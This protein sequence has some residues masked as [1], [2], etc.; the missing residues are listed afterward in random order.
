MATC[1]VCATPLPAGSRFCFACG[2]QV[3]NPGEHEHAPETP[4]RA[5]EFLARLRDRLG[6]EY[7]IERE[8]GR[9]GM[10]IVYLAREKA[11]DR[12]VALKVLPPALAFD[13]SIG[14]RFLREARLAAR[15]DH[16]NI[17]PIHRVGQAG[18]I[19]YFAMKYVAGGSLQALLKNTPRLS[20]HETRRIL[21]ACAHALGYAHARG[22]VH[23]DVK[24]ANILLD[25]GGRVYVTDLGIAKAAAAEG[26]LTRSGAVIGTP[27]YMAPEQCRGEAAD[28]RSDQ[29]ALAIVGYQMLAGR[30]PF[31]QK[32]MEG[33]MYDRLFTDPEPL[34]RIAPD[35]PTVVRDA[36]HRALSREPADRFPT[37]EE[38]AQAVV[39][40]PVEV[41][42]TT[43][44]GQT[45]RYSATPTAGAPVAPAAP[46]RGR[47]RAR[48][49]IAVAAVA[50]A[51]GGG[52]WWIWLRPSGDEAAQPA[53]V[54][55]P[56]A[57]ESEGAGAGPSSAPTAARWR[58]AGAPPEGYRLAIDGADAAERDGELEPGPHTAS[59]S[60]PGYETWTAER[61]LAAGEIWE[62]RPEMTPTATQPAS[63]PA[64]QGDRRP[65]ETGRTEAPEF[66]LS[67]IRVFLDDGLKL[68]EA[69]RYL[70][71]ADK[72]RRGLESVAEAERQFRPGSTLTRL[73]QQLRTE[74]NR[75]IEACRMEGQP[76][77]PTP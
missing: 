13:E 67:A 41:H 24:P 63:R 4:S 26:S 54:T 48:M 27:M 61:V 6:D 34:D 42:A 9:G 32:S 38:F 50:A 15:L 23:R 45:V 53:I 36:I 12:H 2:T 55:S 73:K 52:G 64:A 74:L 7:E 21:A 57:G 66:V 49:W 72:Y 56:T 60:A 62:I 44:V 37:M 69:A 47:R 22:I 68:W 71:A 70:E 77:C 51:A 75:A 30:L 14:E 33:I 18:D 10:G 8:I 58:L 11:L 31:E 29:Y 40:G 65:E 39:G 17:V 28:A 59:V 5:Q 76:N 43:P 20:L 35:V 19:T 46:A 3:S 16:P 25:T 1:Q